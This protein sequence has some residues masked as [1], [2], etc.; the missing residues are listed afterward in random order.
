[1]LRGPGRGVVFH[2]CRVL[3]RADI[4]QVHGNLRGSEDVL[5][6]GVSIS[7]ANVRLLLWY[8]R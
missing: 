6:I 1:M 8:G 2:S 7:V 5:P 3:Q 4:F